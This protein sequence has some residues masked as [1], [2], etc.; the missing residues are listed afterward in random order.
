L[1]GGTQVAV[2]RLFTIA[3]ILTLATLGGANAARGE[4]SQAER[5]LEL[6]EADLAG[7]N[8]ERASKAAASALRLDPGLLQALVVKALAYRALG[9]T[10]EAR[11]LLRTY[12]DL[13]EGLEPDS[14]VGPALVLLEAELEPFEVA[15]SLAAAEAATLELEISVAEAHLRAVRGAGAEGGTLKRVI[16]LEALAAWSDDRPDDAKAKWRELFT[17]FPDSVVDPELQPEAMR[18]MAEAQGEVRATAKS[19]VASKPKTALKPLEPPH[20][21]SVI[22]MGAGGGAAAFGAAFGSTSHDQGMDVYPGLETDPTYWDSNHTAYDA[23]RDQERVGV[24]VAAAG[25][26]ALVGGI[27]HLIVDQALKDKRRKAGATP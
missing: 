24:A 18:L 6:A 23:F 22:L 20:A 2:E 21:A 16:E 15:S 9:R 3:L 25:S 4:S 11:A 14:R 26:A 12:L 17:S 7:G 1:A 10:E 19:P 5:Q 8:A 27:V 13:R